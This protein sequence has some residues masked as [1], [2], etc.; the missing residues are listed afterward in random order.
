MT[1]HGFRTTASSLLNESNRWNPDA[2]ERVLAHSDSNQ[3]RAAYNR[4]AYWD[5][6]VQMMQWWSDELDSLKRLGAR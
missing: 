3:V 1:A 2:I 5:E 4:T 6:R